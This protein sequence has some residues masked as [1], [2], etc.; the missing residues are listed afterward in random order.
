VD[1]E[2]LMGK[3][4]RFGI[5]LF[6]EKDPEKADIAIVNTC[7]FIGDA[8]EESID[9]ILRMVKAKKQGVF[10]KVIVMGCLS[11]RY[12]DDLKKELPGIDGIFGVDEQSELL[13]SIGIN[14][15]KELAGERIL[16][17]PSHYAYLKIAEGCDRECSFCAIPGIRGKHLSRPIE[18]LIEEATI[19]VAGGVKEINLISQD[20]TYYGLDLYGKRNLAQLL[21]QLS[22]VQ[23]LEWLRLHYAYPLS[24]PTDILDVIRERPN[25]CNYMDIPLQHIDSKIL[26]SMR[27]GVSKDQTMKLLDTIRTK[28]PGIAIRTTL[29]AGYPGET[30]KEFQDLVKFVEEQRFERLGIFAYSPEEGTPAFGLG[31]PV[32]EEDKKTRI[33]EIMQVQSEISLDLNEAKI[34]QSEKVI[35]DR[36]EDGIYYGRTAIDS[37]EVDNEVIIKSDNPLN[38]GEFYEVKITGA[39]FFDL[40]GTI[41]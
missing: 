17:T 7:G 10:E 25:I 19:L 29:I 21:D 11:Q 35:I 4:N 1:S 20:T 27:R 24:F 14:Y 37:P 26:K 5:E 38:I 12:R 28:V 41:S 32:S 36:L 18:E 22:R 9:T 30:E 16:T 33:D 23:G 15:K 2:R 3:L 13:Q 8:K 34:G 40:L 39:E 6:H 31:D